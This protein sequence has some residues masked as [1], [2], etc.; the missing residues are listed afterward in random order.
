MGFAPP[1]VFLIFDATDS[2]SGHISAHALLTDLCLFTRNSTGRWKK[3]SVRK[4]RLYRTPGD[5]QD[6]DD[7]L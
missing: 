4:W 2:S 6:D 3:P 1:P 5:D 7:A